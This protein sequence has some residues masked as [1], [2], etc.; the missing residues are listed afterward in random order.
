MHGIKNAAN[1]PI[2]P[3]IKIAHND[4]LEDSVS[5]WIVTALAGNKVVDAAESVKRI[6]ELLSASGTVISAWVEPDWTGIVNSNSAGGKQRSSLHTINSSVPA[7]V[8]FGTSKEIFCL[9]TT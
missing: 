9:N 4:P 6:D 3:A 7:I 5:D 8:V 2:N 1:P